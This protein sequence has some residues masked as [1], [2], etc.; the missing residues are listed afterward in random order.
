M[1]AARLPVRSVTL[2][3]ATAFFGALPTAFGAAAPSAKPRKPIYDEKADAKAD[4][5]DALARAGLDNRRVLV[6]YGGNWCGWCYK[7]HDLFEQ[8]KEI[9]RTLRAEYEPVL[10]DIR[11]NRATAEKYKIER[12]KGVPYL[13]MLD[14]DGKVVANQG[15]GVLE[16]GP[17][18]DPAKVLAFLKKWKAEPLDAEEVIRRALTKAKA[19]KKMVFLRIGAPWCG[20]CVRFDDFLCQKEIAAILAR[21]F[22]PLKIDLERMKNGK[23]AAKRFRDKPGGIPWFAFLDASGEKLVTSDGPKG[24]AGCPVTAEEIAHFKTML[25]KTAR[26]ITPAQIKQ[27][28]EALRERGRKQTKA[29]E[30]RRWET[31]P[32]G[33]WTGR[34]GVLTPESAIQWRRGRKRSTSSNAARMRHLSASDTARFGLGPPHS[35]HVAHVSVRRACRSRDLTA[36]SWPRAARVATGPEAMGVCANKVAPCQNG[37]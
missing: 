3:A 7:L 10:V 15:T 18:H 36:G 35:E 12:D 26:S 19:E 14:A 24:N 34:D 2:F 23:K 11:K 22:V 30:R 5:A 28:V 37:S 1:Q 4:I 13:T 27:I 6:I 8:D 21:D 25:T 33:A 32:E 17:K 20:W 16:E 9:R 29:S 31:A